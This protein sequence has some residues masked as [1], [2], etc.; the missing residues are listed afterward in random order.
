MNPSITPVTEGQKNQFAT[1]LADA[2][3]KAAGT[4]VEEFSQRGIIHVGNFQK[5]VE[6]GDQIAATVLTAVRTKVAEIAESVIGRLRLISGAVTV[7]IPATD[8]TR[9]V[10]RS[11]ELFKGYFDRNFERGGLNVLS[12][13]APETAVE[14]WEMVQEGTFAEI[15]D[16]LDTPL[17][18]LCLTQ[19]QIVAFVESNPKWLH[20]DGYET[21]FLFKE[22]VKGEQ[23]FFVANVFVVSGGLRVDVY[24]V[25]LGD[26]WYA[27]C[28]LRFVLPQLTA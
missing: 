12:Q 18:M 15:Y 9:A 28:H 20:T 8:G 4:V 23:K 2:V 24:P 6:R 25:S 14:V 17:E 3:R 10:Y 16:G 5:V 22:K 7:L 13:P 1:V 26:V 19:A 21:F 27:E 11:K